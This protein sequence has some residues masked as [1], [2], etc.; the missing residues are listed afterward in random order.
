MVDTLRLKGEAYSLNSSIGP[1]TVTTGLSTGEVWRRSCA[2]ENL[3]CDIGPDNILRLQIHSAPGLLH[4]TSLREVTE[5][6]YPAFTRALDY[7]LREE[8]GLTLDLRDFDVTRAD[9]C[10]NLLVEHSP[11]DYITALASFAVSRRQKKVFASESVTWQN[12]SRALI[13]YD[14]VQAVLDKEKSADILALARSSP[15]ILRAEARIRQGKL[16]R[17][18][19]GSPRPTLREVW[20]RELSRG[21][22]LREFDAL[23]KMP[24][25]PLPLDFESEV[26]RLQEYRARYRRGAANMYL[27]ASFAVPGLLVRFQSDWRLILKLLQA[28]GYSRSQANEIARRLRG[29]HGQSIPRRERNLVREVRRLLAA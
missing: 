23:V 17:A 27:L 10:R 26:R 5:K 3:H 28:G 29:V 19:L 15:P 14:K 16:V 7:A 22:L 2:T 1:W 20:N 13:F 6:E 8:A 25:G 18:L 21:Y 11:A 4:G 24:D 9:F 12:D